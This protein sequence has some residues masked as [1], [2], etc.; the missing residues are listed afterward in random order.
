MAAGVMPSLQRRCVRRDTQ[1]G[2]VYTHWCRRR[3]THQPLVHARARAP[4]LLEPPREP[5]WAVMRVQP[6]AGRPIGEPAME[7]PMLLGVPFAWNPFAQATASRRMNAVMLFTRI[8]CRRLGHSVHYVAVLGCPF[9]F[10]LGNG[11]DILLLDRLQTCRI[12]WNSYMASRKSHHHL[13][14]CL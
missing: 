6:F 14:A 2:R 4:C 12:E 7:L 13:Q 5:L 11:G 8:A 3:G 10:L 1:W 9:D